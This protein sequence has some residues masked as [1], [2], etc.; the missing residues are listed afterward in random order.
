VEKLKIEQSKSACTQRLRNQP[1]PANP[2]RHAAIYDA[3]I[4]KLTRAGSSAKH[5]NRL[6][7]INRN[8]ITQRT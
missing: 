4:P 6:A 2:V 7:R 1:Q 5:G 8:A 3:R